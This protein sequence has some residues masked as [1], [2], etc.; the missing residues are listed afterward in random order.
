MTVYQYLFSFLT[1]A[2]VIT[3][4]QLNRP[5]KITTMSIINEELIINRI[6]ARLV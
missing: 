1:M 6:S 5:E 3:S 2:A 4:H